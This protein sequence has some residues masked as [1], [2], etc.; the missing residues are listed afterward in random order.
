MAVGGMNALT[1][2]RGFHIGQTPYHEP[3]VWVRLQGHGAVR[4]VGC[5]L[6]WREIWG[7]RTGLIDLIDEIETSYGERMNGVGKEK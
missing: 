3:A 1:L 5:L 4:E 7:V 2:V 6:I